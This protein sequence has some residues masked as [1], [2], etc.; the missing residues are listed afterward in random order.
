M[1]E[2]ITRPIPKDAASIAGEILSRMLQL[3]ES[4]G[5]M[6]DARGVEITRLLRQQ[7]EYRVAA[8]EK[9]VCPSCAGFTIRAKTEYRCTCPP[10]ESK[11]R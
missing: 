6:G 8:L 1:T 9:A 5:E 7:W 3:E 11:K 4:L 2:I 10:K